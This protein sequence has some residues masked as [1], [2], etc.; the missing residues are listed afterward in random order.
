M[1]FLYLASQAKNLLDPSLWTIL[2]LPKTIS[3]EILRSIL[4]FSFQPPK[5]LVVKTKSQET[6]MHRFINEKAKISLSK[7][8]KAA[9]TMAVIVTTFIVC[10]LPFFLMYVILPFCK[11]CSPSPKVTMKFSRLNSEQALYTT[12]LNEN[13]GSSDFVHDIWI[14]YKVQCTIFCTLHFRFLLPG[15][16]LCTLQ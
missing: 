8:R 10:W 16:K 14:C 9:R 4:L 13:R 1:W 5:N 6:D 7:E 12:G 15:T 11:T 3:L 2:Y